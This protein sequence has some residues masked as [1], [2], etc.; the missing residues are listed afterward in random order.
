M[1]GEEVKE[2]MQMAEEGIRAQ[3]RDPYTAFSNC[4]RELNYGNSYFFRVCNL[5]IF[6]W[7]CINIVG[8]TLMFVSKCIAAN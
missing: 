3:E 2:V 7:L 4:V 8:I 1:P 5:L 6:H